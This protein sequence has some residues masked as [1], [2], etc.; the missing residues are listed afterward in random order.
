M[1]SQ[2]V[3]VPTE[4]SAFTQKSPTMQMQV[5]KSNGAGFEARDVWHPDVYGCLIC[6]CRN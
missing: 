2:L 5:K 3:E 1:S 4:A 6:Q